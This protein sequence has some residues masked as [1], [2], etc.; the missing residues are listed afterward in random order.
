MSG[1]NEEKPENKMD[2]YYK[3]GDNYF[4]CPICGFKKRVSDGRYRWD[5]EFVCK[6]DWEAKHPQESVKARV[7]RMAARI[8]RPEPVDTFIDVLDVTGE[9]L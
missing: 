5:R 7:D 2:G 1:R 8:S 4:L 6:E 9:D 3:S